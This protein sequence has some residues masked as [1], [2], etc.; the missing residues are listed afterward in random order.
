MTAITGLIK[1]VAVPRLFQALLAEKKTGAAIFGLGTTVKKVY[2]SEGEIVFAMSNV[3]DDRLGECLIRIG[4]LTHEQRDLSLQT[5]LAI[6]K[7]L[8]AV[9]IESKLITSQQLVAGVSHQIKQITISVFNWYGGVLFLTKVLFQIL[10]L[11]RL[12]LSN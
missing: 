7:K 12:V 2:I 6:G 8:G 3:I 4:A 5:S 10:F 9:L 11:L 1:D